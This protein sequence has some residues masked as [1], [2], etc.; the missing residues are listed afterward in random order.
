MK[1]LGWGVLR[2]KGA[3]DIYELFSNL[4]E[5]IKNAGESEDIAP[6]FEASTQIY[7]EPDA[8]AKPVKLT[9]GRTAD[10][11]S[12]AWAKRQGFI[13][14]DEFKTLRHWKKSR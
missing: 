8:Y 3:Q 5:A 7:D 1:M 2:E 4:E 9:D 12:A 11:A 6:T 14:P 10:I 13:S